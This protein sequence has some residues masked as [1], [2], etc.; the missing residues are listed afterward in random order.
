M[1]ELRSRSRGSKS[2]R[3]ENTMKIG[4]FSVALLE[5]HIEMGILGGTVSEF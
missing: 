4:L 5:F 2:V 1:W 3:E